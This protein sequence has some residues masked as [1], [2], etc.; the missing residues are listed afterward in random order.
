MQQQDDATIA[1]VRRCLPQRFAE[2]AAA[3]HKQLMPADRVLMARVR[4]LGVL[5]GEE[6]IRRTIKL[7]GAK[8]YEMHQLSTSISKCLTIL[9]R[10]DESD[11]QAAR[12]RTRVQ[13]A[14]HQS[15]RTARELTDFVARVQQRLAEGLYSEKLAAETSHIPGL[16]RQSRPIT[17]P[18]SI[19]IGPRCGVAVRSIHAGKW[20]PLPNKRMYRLQGAA[21]RQVNA[22]LRA[23]GAPT[24]LEP[25]EVAQLQARPIMDSA[26]LA[27]NADRRQLILDGM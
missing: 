13:R 8:A 21:R 11:S 15:I 25:R 3:R 14:W 5:G 4:K 24:L 26:E 23:Q 16:S 10:T 18:A 7:A 27:A 22:C 1:A 20:A 12:L 9:G 6:S 19:R 2:L 17:D